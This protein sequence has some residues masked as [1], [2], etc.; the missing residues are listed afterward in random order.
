MSKARANAMMRF[1]E[2]QKWVHDHGATVV[3]YV[4][5]YGSKNDPDHYG[6]GGEAIY[7]ADIAELHRC[8]EEW[9]NA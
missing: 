1:F 3:G 6:N 8:W 9:R 2:Q 4:I 5:R 7:A